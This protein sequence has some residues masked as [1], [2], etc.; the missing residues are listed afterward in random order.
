MAQHWGTGAPFAV[1]AGVSA[2]VLLLAIFALPPLRH[3]LQGS[4]SYTA[5][6]WVVLF[7]PAH[8]WAYAVMTCLV[9]GIFTIMPFLGDVSGGERRPARNDAPQTMYLIGG[10][11][12]LCT[13][14]LFGKL[15]D[16]YGKLLVFR[17][18][19]L[20][21]ADSDSG[22][23]EPAANA[24]GAHRPRSLPCSFMV[25]SSG[26]SGKPV[27]ALITSSAQPSYR[28]SFMS[29]IASVQQAASGLASL[30]AGALLSQPEKD[31]PL[32]G[33]WLAGLLAC[34]ATVG[35]VILAGYVR[36]AVQTAPVT[37][38]AAAPAAELIR[39]HSGEELAQVRY[40]RRD[41]VVTEGR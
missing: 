1:L 24:G 41:G 20:A 34:A 4:S 18:M 3:H 21:D 19:A 13:M 17:I 28:G 37:E 10:L 9:L 38:P 25:V 11:A 27:M 26:R 7:H 30:L 31:G 33:Y 32:S 35:S 36:P 6:L 5:S 16:I 22:A 40:C 14:S 2:V 12:T 29:I 23:D 15:A 39:V 8:L